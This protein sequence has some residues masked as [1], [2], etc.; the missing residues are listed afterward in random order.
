MNL[1][2]A[3]L[4]LKVG[5]SECYLVLFEPPG[6]PGPPGRRVVLPPPLPVLVVLVLTVDKSLLSFPDDRLRL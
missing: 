2:C 4:P 5:G 3:I 6:L 1:E